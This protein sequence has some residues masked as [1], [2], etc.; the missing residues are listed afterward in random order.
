ML[1][2]ARAALSERDIY[3]RTH[4]GTRRQFREAFV[5]GGEFDSELLS[6]VRAT[7]PEREQADYEAWLTPVREADRV[8]D[9]AAM[10]V[11]AR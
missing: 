11:E 3:A 5:Q 2:A 8:I 6:A 4:A 9:L 1:Y 7:Q 10:F